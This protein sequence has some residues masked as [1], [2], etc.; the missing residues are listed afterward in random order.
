[1]RFLDQENVEPVLDA[2]LPEK[3]FPA[4]RQQRRSYLHLR[5]ITDAHAG[6]RGWRVVLDS[7]MLFFRRPDAVLEWL[8][9]PDRAIH[10][11]DVKDSYGYPDATL[12]SLAGRPPPERLNVGI[13]GLRSDAI[14]WEK[15]EFWC[16]R[17]LA[18]HG[19][20]YYLEQALCALLLVE[21]TPLRLPAADYIVMPGD[22]EC[23]APTAVLHH[24]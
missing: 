18:L 13:C 4:L 21:T 23:R 8:A 12:T 17:L 16:A 9:A 6:H 1:A 5:K 24:Y 19:S 20:S 3:K 14:D 2:C 11:L 15:L 10:M 22:A 7:D